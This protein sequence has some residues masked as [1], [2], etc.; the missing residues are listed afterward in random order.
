MEN[1]NQIALE[2]IRW[3]YN[4]VHSKMHYTGLSIEEACEVVFSQFD[5]SEPAGLLEAVKSYHAFR[6]NK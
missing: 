1:Q 5:G 6:M 3:A 2:D 4:L